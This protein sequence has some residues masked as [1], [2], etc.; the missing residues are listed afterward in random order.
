[1]ICA[2]VSPVSN[3]FGCSSVRFR[4]LAL[5]KQKA[6][7]V[8]TRRSP[9]PPQP[10]G[11]LGLVLDFVSIPDINWANLRNPTVRFG[12]VSIGSSSDQ[13]RFDPVP[14]PFFFD[15]SKIGCS[16]PPKKVDKQLSLLINHHLLR[17]M[18]L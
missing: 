13:F 7:T 18:I 16:I 11:L 14:V 5:L 12:S 1:M 15:P 6:K 9:K 2:R 4:G 8:D 10:R 3:L 17:S